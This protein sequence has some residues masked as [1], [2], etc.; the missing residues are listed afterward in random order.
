M[1]HL[2]NFM[3]FNKNNFII[4]TP[5]YCLVILV[6]YNDDVMRIQNANNVTIKY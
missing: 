5:P 6:F 4:V 1:L 3:S 2:K